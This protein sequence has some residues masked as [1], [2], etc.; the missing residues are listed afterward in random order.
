[1][2]FSNIGPE[3]SKEIRSENGKKIKAGIYPCLD[4][5]FTD[6]VAD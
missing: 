1:M 4:F 3:C 5:E 6:C 2:K